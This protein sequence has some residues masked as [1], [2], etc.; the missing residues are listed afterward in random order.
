MFDFQKIHPIK[1]LL[2]K[3]IM[4]FVQVNTQC[5]QGE[6][7]EPLHGFL[8]TLVCIDPCIGNAH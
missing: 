3:P 8:F 6:P 4:N 2:L 5:L 7:D 1:P